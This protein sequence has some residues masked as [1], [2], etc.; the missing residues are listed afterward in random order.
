MIS[1]IIP[2]KALS[3]Y[4]KEIDKRDLV[5]NKDFYEWLRGFTDGEGNFYISRDKRKA[6]VFKF[7]FRIELHRNDRPLLEYI[8]NRLKIGK[9]YPLELKDTTRKSSWEVYNKKD[10]ENLIKIFDLNDFNTTKQLDFLA[11]REAYFIHT[12]PSPIPSRTGHGARGPC[13]IGVTESGT[14][15]EDLNLSICNKTKEILRLK[16]T[17]NSNRISFFQSEHHKIKITPYWLLGLI[18]GEGS[19]WVS[20]NNLIQCFEIGLTLSQKPVIEAISNYLLSLIP[21]KISPE[22]NLMNLNE[23]KTLMHLNI[24]PLPCPVPRTGRD[25]GNK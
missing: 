11:W 2:I 17:M 13:G 15:M 5:K 6:S 3:N 19:F 12:L 8:Q 21:S 20:K 24:K 22:Y 23:L 9:V 4:S 25:G 14:E 1:S 10:V 16:Q 18:E 7:S